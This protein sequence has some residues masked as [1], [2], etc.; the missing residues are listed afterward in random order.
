MQQRLRAWTTVPAL[1]ALAVSVG[2]APASERPDGWRQWGGDD[3]GFTFDPKP[4]NGAWQE[5]HPTLL[6][7]RALG[8]GYSAVVTDGRALYTMYADGT[9]EVVVQLDGS[10]RDVAEFRSTPGSQGPRS[11]GGPRSTPLIAGKRLVTIGASSDLY[12]LD[13]RTLEPLWQMNLWERFGGN[14]LV[15]GYASSPI[16]DGERLIVPVGG[17]GASVV[18][19][20][21]ASDS[22]WPS[23]RRSSFRWTRR[24]AR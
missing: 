11:D 20:D 24:T 12:C 16:R 9:E 17:P 6:E 10:L 5:L 23:W 13:A 19:L 14:P 4:F 22:S 15:Y 1:L 7:R 8:P 21:L 3:G 2:L 18:A